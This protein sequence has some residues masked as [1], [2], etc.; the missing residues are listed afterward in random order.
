MK[1]RKQKKEKRNMRPKCEL[2]PLS[3]TTTMD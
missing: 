2:G 1:G 3:K